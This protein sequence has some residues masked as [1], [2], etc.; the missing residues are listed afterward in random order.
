V[1]WID[2]NGVAM[3]YEL[4]GSDRR[5]LVLIHEM[6]GA[7]ESWDLVLPALV[8]RRRVLRYDVRGAGLSEKI[9]GT[10]SIDDAADDLVALLDALD[11]P[12]PVAVAGCAVGAAIAIRAA[13]RF[14]ERVGA[15][16]AMAPATGIPPER[17]AETLAFADRLEREGVRA[18]I[19]DRSPRSYPEELRQD[20]E[21][22]RQ[23]R[24][25]QLCSDPESYAATYR[26]LVHLAMEGD[27]ARIRCPT[28]VI[29]GTLDQ[30]R[31]PSTVEPVARAIANARFEV[32]R[33]GHFMALQ[34][35]ELVA[36]LVA[37]FLARLDL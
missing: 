9:R 12:G 16:I 7:L 37:D 11:I 4:S 23:F 31:P 18:S 29:A 1:N 24:A 33:T 6:G 27:F 13:A 8:E 34:S 26:M 36:P 15:L 2:V 17:R 25:R 22:F 3:R 35:P 20:T 14:G 30:S 10:L 32:L 19:G 21:R 5:L 28:L